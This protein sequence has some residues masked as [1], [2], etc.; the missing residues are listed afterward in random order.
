MLWQRHKPGK[1]YLFTAAAVSEPEA[2]ERGS[3]L[4]GKKLH[5]RGIQSLFLTKCKEL[6]LS[7][8]GRFRMRSRLARNCGYAG[9]GDFECAVDY[10][11]LSSYTDFQL[12]FE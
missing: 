5:H 10:H 6:W 2:S 8:N 1:T 4:I 9:M 11:V 12:Q 3:S 7:A